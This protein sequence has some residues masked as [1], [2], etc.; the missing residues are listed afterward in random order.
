MKH[1]YK[2]KV[3]FSETDMAG[4]VHN[5]K[6][7]IY[8]EE[9]RIDLFA[10]NNLAY[11]KL[12]AS[13][14][15]LPIVDLR[16]KIKKPITFDDNILIEIYFNKIKTYQAKTQYIIKNDEGEIVAEGYTH[17]AFLS[18]QSN[19]FIELPAKYKELLQKYSMEKGD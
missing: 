14:I 15:F 17:H 5:S 8:F 18:T 12:Q 10:K 13:G 4:L 7:L 19:D 2:T 1:I 11:K 6:Y 16:I 3:R 9:A